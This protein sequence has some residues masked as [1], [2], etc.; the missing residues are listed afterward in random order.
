ME[1]KLGRLCLAASYKSY[2]TFAFKHE[3]SRGA[4][5]KHEAGRNITIKSLLRQL[6]IHQMILALALHRLK[7]RSLLRRIR[8]ELLDGFAPC[9]ASK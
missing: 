1:A 5:W 6:N 8:K 7:K 2:E 3:L 4:Y 9:V